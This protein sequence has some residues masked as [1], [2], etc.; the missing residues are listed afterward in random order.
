MFKIGSHQLI[1]HLNNSYSTFGVSLNK[2]SYN[3][4]K[5][6][7]RTQKMWILGTKQNIVSAFNVKNQARFRNANIGIVPAEAAL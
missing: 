2:T 3:G 1:A 6:H 5:F 4:D 7:I